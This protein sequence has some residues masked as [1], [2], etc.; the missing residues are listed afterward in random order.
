MVRTQVRAECCPLVALA[1][2]GSKASVALSSQNP[3]GFQFLPNHQRV[4]P[5]LFTIPFIFRAGAGGP[6]KL[7]KK[8]MCKA[9]FSHTSFPTFR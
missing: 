8:P 4:A 5:T 9:I 3:C 1:N 7:S 2:L 6:G